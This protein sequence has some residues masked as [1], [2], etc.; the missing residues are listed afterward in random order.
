[1]RKITLNIPDDKFI[2]IVKLWAYK[3][4]TTGFN[5]GVDP[6]DWLAVEFIRRARADAMKGS[7]AKR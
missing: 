5:P 6:L 7:E 1:M 2:E 4:M 3:R